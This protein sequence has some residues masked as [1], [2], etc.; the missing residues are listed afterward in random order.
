MKLL[1]Y[2]SSALTSKSSHFDNRVYLYVSYESEN[3]HVFILNHLVFIMKVKCVFCEVE[4][5]SL[6]GLFYHAVSISDH[7]RRI[8]G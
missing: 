1:P 7:T 5:L 2:V 3:K 8:V 6:R 4:C